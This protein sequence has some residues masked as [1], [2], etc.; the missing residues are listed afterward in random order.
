MRHSVEH[1]HGV[2]AT[3]VA[4]SNGQRRV[5]VALAKIGSEWRLTAWAWAKGS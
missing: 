4:R 2:R 5:A 3:R 1:S